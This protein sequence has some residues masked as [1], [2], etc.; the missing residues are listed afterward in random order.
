[1]GC[2][3]VPAVGAASSMLR[4][5]V[6]RE[7]RRGGL[8][9]VVNQRVAKISAGRRRRSLATVS[10]LAFLLVVASLA[11]AAVPTGRVPL[12]TA[13][14]TTVV[15]RDEAPGPKLSAA[16][17]PA[18]ATTLAAWDFAASPSTVPSA[19]AVLLDQSGRPLAP[20]FALDPSPPPITGYHVT[21]GGQPVVAY[22]P[23]ADAWVVLVEADYG[24]DQTCSQVVRGRRRVFP[25]RAQ[26]S[27]LSVRIDPTGH[28]SSPV[29]VLQVPEAVV[30][31]TAV[32]ESVYG[33]YSLSCRAT[34][35]IL[36]GHECLNTT[37]FGCNFNKQVRE[38]ALPLDS[39]GAP[40]TQTL[41][42]IDRGGHARCPN[43][44]RGIVWPATGPAAVSATDRGYLVAWSTGGD[45]PPYDCV[46]LRAV[47]P[48]G[49]PNGS[50]T[51]VNE[52]PRGHYT[53][54]PPPGNIRYEFDF[55]FP[56]IC[57]SRSGKRALATWF[58]GSG[59][60]ALPSP[61][62]AYGPYIGVYRQ[63][64]DSAGRLVGAD[65]RAV[66]SIAGYA[67]T[68]NPFTAAYPFSVQTLAAAQPQDRCVVLAAG[69]NHVDAYAYDLSGRIRQHSA[70][71]RY[72]RPITG[73]IPDNALGLWSASGGVVLDM[74]Y[75]GGNA[76]ETI[77]S[78]GLR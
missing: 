63:S 50:I 74:S 71:V 41:T 59:G 67:P 70:V 54:V 48:T 28:P 43:D 31:G 69:I 61:P 36:L 65:T 23:S 52:N 51:V 68:R 47:G 25:C 72:H 14:S 5:I 55:S 10:A 64:Y 18:S 58:V 66:R 4:P 77:R 56:Q 53:L 21:G 44:R 20:V 17:R 38:F 60:Y 27:L 33:P 49:A 34:G 62:T 6:S 24:S 40:L 78:Y 37:V 32:A 13:A 26:L 19:Q 16:I 1:M 57:V 39:G 3:A 76:P 9:A 29:M 75:K 73:N 11:Y 35:C 8:V 46:L 45:E 7:S 42:A 30:H 22:S 15:A 2:A 12:R